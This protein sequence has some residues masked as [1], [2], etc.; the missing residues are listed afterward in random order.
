MTPRPGTA[1]DP[2]PARLAEVA[3]WDA[4]VLPGAVR[5]L[6][7]VVS[8][9]P[10]WRYRLEAVGRALESAPVWSG[11][12]AAGAA[13]AVLRLSDA[14]TAV[15]AAMCSSLAGFERLVAA[16]GRAAPL[17]AEALALEAVTAPA[18][19]AVP[20]AA[21]AEL[22][23]QA[24]DH[25]AAADRAADDA[26]DAL[27]AV[28]VRDGFPPAGYGQ[29]AAEIHPAGPVVLPSLTATAAE[30]AR[31]WTGLPAGAQRAVLSAEPRLLGALDGLPG[32]ARD[33]ANRRL[34]DLALRSP[35]RDVRAAAVVVGAAI[36]SREAN[37]GRV[38]LH[39]FDPE[40]GLVALALGDLDTGE[41]VALL[42]PGIW[43]T[44]EDDLTGLLDDAAA[45]GAA[46]AVTAPGL[47]V[48]PV[49]WLGYRTPQGLLAPLFRSAARR[50]GPALDGALDGL[51]AARAATGVA[52]AR[53]T[54]LAHSYG[55][56]V[57]DEAADAAGRLAADAVVLLGSPGMEPGG[58]AGLE[59]R[60]VH[61]AA[62]LADPISWSG[63]FGDP[64]WTPGF[65]SEVL[66]TR[67]DTGHTEYYD[68]DH[69]T[70][71]SLGAV[72]AGAGR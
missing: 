21:A 4:A 31:W 52:P 7:G 55:T 63:W 62:S 44:P 70:L 39:Q 38:H 17:A 40:R 34:L 24:L 1:G 10:A 11:P 5:R 33:R 28:G 18:L 37:G 16:A 66:P 54:V 9:L 19:D 65:G 60:D 49:A 46:A 56:V 61:D 58:A 69:P 30:V 64:T 23:R 50:G 27:V 8:R 26:A 48:V 45:V 51:A 32:W 15:T 13:G 20:G 22:T 36:R 25:A 67:I 2:G 12:A 47:A 53:T 57:V 29:L 35:D 41:A 72:V 14:A 68:A 42:V 71:A 6:D 43:T 3:A 59:V